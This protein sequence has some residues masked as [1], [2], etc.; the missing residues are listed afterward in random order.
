MYI[1][2]DKFIN[3]VSN[4]KIPSAYW[5]SHF[6]ENWLQTINLNE[7][8]KWLHF[9]ID[10]KRAYQKKYKTENK[11]LIH[12]YYLRNREIYIERAKKRY[13]DRKGK[14]TEDLRTYTKTGKSRDYKANKQ[15]Y[16][17][18]HKRYVK[19]NKK[20]IREYMRN[21]MKKWSANLSEEEKLKR[22]EYQKQYR[23][24]HK[25]GNK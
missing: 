17:L 5:L 12:E 7:Y 4:T 22:K 20:K 1:S 13:L 16:D 6:H 21:Y 2:I 11:D 25:G 8:V 3:Y 14:A 24:K 23:L 19:K 18:Y 9:L 10:K 15:K